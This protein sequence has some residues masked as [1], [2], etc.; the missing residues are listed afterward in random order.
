[1]VTSFTLRK[2]WCFLFVLQK[3]TSFRHKLRE[4]ENAVSRNVSGKIKV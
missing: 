4:P 3:S 1:M 2:A